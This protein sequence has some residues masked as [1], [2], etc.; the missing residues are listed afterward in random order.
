MTTSIVRTLASSLN[1]VLHTF[2]LHISRYSTYQ[3]V[4]QRSW[5]PKDIEALTLSAAQQLARAGDRS[6]AEIEAELA[7]ASWYHTYEILPGIM[8]PGRSE[9]NAKA[10]LDQNDIPQDLSGKKALDIGAWDGPLSFE[11]ERRGAEVTAL[12]IQYP[13]N[14]GFNVAKRILNSRVRY[15]QASVYDLTTV[16]K[17]KFDLICFLG[18]FY[19]LKHPIY[20]FEQIASALARDGLVLFGG[21]C[22]LQYAET[23]KGDPSPV[24]IKKIAASDVPVALCYPGRY[25]NASNWFVPN[26]ACLRSWMQACGLEMIGYETTMPGPTTFPVQRIHGAARKVSDLASTEEHTIYQKNWG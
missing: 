14:T 16:L 25:K 26:V 8:T 3:W 5:D 20:A 13:D 23:L 10:L 9:F 2:N 4:A 7:T 21:E 15:I 6:R 17:E 12:D 19:H 22:L 11:L 1:R 24:D 18:V